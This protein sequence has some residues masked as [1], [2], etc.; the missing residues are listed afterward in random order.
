MKITTQ[1]EFYK[2]FGQIVTRI[3]EQK[4]LIHHLTN[5]V[6][7]GDCANIAICFGAS[8]VMADEISEMEEITGSAD[9]LVLNL[10]TINAT[11]FLSMQKAQSAAH[12]KHIPIILDPVGVMASK[13]RHDAAQLL[14][15]SGVSILRGNYDEVKT[16]FLGQS[17]GKGVDSNS[18]ALDSG[19]LAQSV[20]AKY[21]CVCVITG[22]IDA[23]SDGEQ[24]IFI[25]NGHQFLTKVTGAGCMSTT[26]IACAA[27]V[28]ENK[29][30]AAACGLMTM[31]FAAEEAASVLHNSAGPGSFK[32]RLF[33]AVY[34]L[35]EGDVSI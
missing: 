20:A 26:L 14:L 17:C 35:A 24:T 8:P 31:N 30:L 12:K 25:E 29:L 27:A 7:A 33:D 19:T 13:M 21:N 1:A 18:K 4:P 11:K 32:V 34:N 10:G 3:Q 6:T 15:K 23:L 22:V 28:W 5:Y 2:E 9:A 16:L